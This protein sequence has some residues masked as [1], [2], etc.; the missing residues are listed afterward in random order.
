MSLKDVEDDMIAFRELIDSECYRLA[1]DFVCQLL[2]PSCV[3]KKEEDELILP[4]RSY[5]REF[6]AGCGGRLPERFRKLLDCNR[7]PEY[8]GPTSCRS[9]KGDNSYMYN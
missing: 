4:C 8:T 5:C 6:W 2:Q 1:Y 9:R 7:F 3:T